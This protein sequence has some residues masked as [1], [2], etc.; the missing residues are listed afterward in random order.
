MLREIPLLVPIGD[1]TVEVLQAG[2]PV[3]SGLT[4]ETGAFSLSGLFAGDNTTIRAQL[5]TSVSAHPEPVVLH[6]QEPVSSSSTYDMVL[7]VTLSERLYGAL[8]RLSNLAVSPGLFY[9]PAQPMQLPQSYVTAPVTTQLDQ[10][11]AELGPD[12]GPVLEALSRLYLSATLMERSFRDASVLSAEW[13]ESLLLMLEQYLTIREVLDKIQ[14]QLIIAGSDTFEANK[15][16]L[17]THMDALAFDMTMQTPLQQAS[18]FVP[19]PYSTAFYDVALRMHD[20]VLRQAALEPGTGTRYSVGF[21]G[22]EKRNGLLDAGIQTL[23]S[24]L[25]VEETGPLIDRMLFAAR[26]QAYS[27][28]TQ[29]AFSGTL[30]SQP[31]STISQLDSLFTGTIRQSDSLQTG[32]NMALATQ[33]LIH[34][35]DQLPSLSLLNELVTEIHSTAPN[36]MGPALEST[37][38]S[39]AQIPGVL[40]QGISRAFTPGNTFPNARGTSMTAS[41]SGTPLLV[42]E[43][44]RTYLAQLDSLVAWLETGSRDSALAVLPALIEADQGYE[45]SLKR[46]QASIWAGISSQQIAP[47]VASTIYDQLTQSIVASIQTRMAIYA[48]LLQ[49]AGHISVDGASLSAHARELA[50]HFTAVETHLSSLITAGASLPGPAIVRHSTN[51]H[52]VPAGAPFDLV[53]TVANLQETSVNNVSIRIKTDSLLT[54]LSSATYTIASLEPGDE[55]ELRWRAQ[56]PD[57]T[58]SGGMYVIETLVFEEVTSV[59]L[60]SYAIGL[61]AVTGQQRE[62]RLPEAY[63]LHPNYPNPFT[64]QTTIAYEVP[65]E[66][67]VTI[68]VYD[69]LGRNVGTLVNARERAG[70]HTV[71]F[72]AAHLPSSTY[73]VRMETDGFTSVRRIALVR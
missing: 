29:D 11:L 54:L 44:A 26:T 37:G 41:P 36:L 59:A 9:E 46:V 40:D 28:T 57:Y 52:P 19:A 38:M 47:E 69:L 45:I 18:A 48:F 6:Y 50:D 27:A 63:V 56:I 60:G 4:D 66:A 20:T 53:A 5:E 23:L 43:P 24:P 67:H 1:A 33:S 3:G 42:D 34:Q 12:S 7:P 14:A 71:S 13:A 15:F 8:G 68:T 35:I 70:R 61:Q 2:T 55:I 32:S 62:A 21:D 39:L 25:Y 73:L 31:G 51:L 16:L 17:L 72:D 58:H 22:S 65:E 64:H 10:W 49:F 30:S